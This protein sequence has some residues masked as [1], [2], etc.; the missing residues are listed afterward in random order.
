MELIGW[1][2]IKIICDLFIVE[3]LLCN[4]FLNKC[5]YSNI[6]EYCIKYS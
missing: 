2:I 3:E 5:Y 1:H 6:K 4:F